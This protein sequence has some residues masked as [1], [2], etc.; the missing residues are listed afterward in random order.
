MVAG[1]D[2]FPPDEKMKLARILILGSFP[3]RK[4]RSEGVGWFYQE[5]D[6]QFWPI[7]RRKYDLRLPTKEEQ[8]QFLINQG[9]VLWDVIGACDT[10]GSAD[11]AI[12]EGSETWNI[13]R[14]VEFVRAHNN[15]KVILN[16]KSDRT[17]RR[18]FRTLI[19]IL[20]EMNITPIELYGTS[21]RNKKYLQEGAKGSNEWLT[22]LD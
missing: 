19:P 11:D 20:K 17:R 4:S 3:G 5:D 7:I 9:I 22:A 13:P 6:N 1:L 15:I 18:F 10:N 12:V 16:G 21:P 14:I 2:R 8:Q